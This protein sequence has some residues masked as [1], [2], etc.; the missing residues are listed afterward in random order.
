MLTAADVN[1]LYPL[2]S[3]GARDDCTQWFMEQHARF[4]QT[5]KNLFSELAHL[6]LTNNYVECKELGD[7]S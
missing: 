3:V 2:Y 7:T 5:L 4:N 6:L 1:A